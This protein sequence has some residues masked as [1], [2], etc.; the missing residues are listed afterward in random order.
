MKKTL[1]VFL[2]LLMLLSV[3]GLPAWAENAVPEV[4]SYAE[5]VAYV[6]SQLTARNGSFT[7][8]YTGGDWTEPTLDDLC[9]Y[10]GDAAAGDYLRLSFRALPQYADNGDGTHTVSAAFY[11]DEE[12]EAAVDAYVSDV[13]LGCT[14][15][16]DYDKA[17][18]IYGYLCDN[19]QFDLENLY[20]EED[21]LKYT[22]YGAAVNGRAVCQG[23]AT[24]FYRLALAAG[25]DCRIVTGTRSDVKHAWNIVKWNGK[26]YHVDAACGAQLLDPSGY[27]M[28]ASLDKYTI[29]Y[30]NETAQEIKNYPFAAV[31]EEEIVIG[32]LG[33]L[34]SYTL[35]NTTGALTVSGTGDVPDGNYSPLLHSVTSAVFEEGITGI[36]GA[37]F[38]DCLFLKEVS[39]PAS[40][41]G[42]ERS[43]FYYAPSIETITVDGQNPVF[44]AAGNCLIKT[45][46]KE[47]YVGCKTSEIPSDGSVTGIGEYAFYCKKIQTVTIPDTVTEIGA[48]A[49]FGAGLTEITIP[50]SVTSIGEAAFSSNPLTSVTVG[51][52][53]RAEIP[54]N[55]FFNC[56]YIGEYCVEG[57]NG[58]Y[59]AEN[60][61]L[62]N[63]DGTVLIRY[64]AAASAESFEIP[65]S[66]TTVSE[67]AFYGSKNLKSVTVPV[68][69]VSLMPSVFS[70][71]EALESVSFA[72]DL[73]QIPDAAFNGCVSL[74]QVNI[75]T[76]VTGIGHDAFASCKALTQIIL[77][78]SVT[79]IDENAFYECTSL[80]EI[81]IPSGVTVIGIR[82]F[83]GCRSLSQIVL[84]AGLTELG[85]EAFDY[86]ISLQ[87]DIRVPGSVKTVGMNTFLNCK[88]LTSVTLGSGV[89]QIGYQA[90]CGCSS[91]NAVVVPD[92]VTS[93]AERAFA[94]SGATLYGVADSY[95]QT[96]AEQQNIP[97]KLI[98]PISG[99]LHRAVAE[100]ATEATCTESA[101][102][103]G[104][105]CADCGAWLTEPEPIG[106]P[107]GHSPAEPVQENR[108]EPTCTQEGA[109]DN[110]VRCSRC[111]EILSSVHEK[112]AMIP[113]ADGDHNGYC[114][115]C[116]ANICEHP[117]TVLLNERESTCTENGYSGD[118]VCAV[119]GVT[120]TYGTTVFAPGHSPVLAAEAAAATCVDKGHTAQYV[121]SA[122]GVVTTESEET[123][124]V[125]HSDADGGGLCDVC[126]SP[127]GCEIFG[128]CGA[129]LFWFAAD[130]VL[131]ISGSGN[132]D[133]F[134]GGAPWEPYE[135]QI[136]TVYIREGV[137]RVYAAGLRS[138]PALKT[139]LKSA[140]ARV[141]GVGVPV[142]SYAFSDGDALL[143]GAAEYT[144]YDL[145]DTAYLLTFDHAVTSLHFETLTLNAA[146]G[147][148]YTEYDILKNGKIIDENHFRIPDGAAL[149]DVRVA[150][151]G[152]RSFNAVL[153][154]IGRNPDKNLILNITCTDLL[155]QEL[156]ADADLYTEQIA[157]R[158]IDEEPSGDDGNGSFLDWIAEQYQATL[159]ALLGL[160]KKVVKFFKSI[161][162]K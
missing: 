23:F 114:D 149:T 27:F 116:G 53:L 135:D 8:R 155:P 126:L 106:D 59:S 70:G 97:F 99:G 69:V 81:N 162:S 144:L 21:L 75:P 145:L 9:A 1:S 142:V 79:E 58:C 24:L 22:A 82:A 44:H 108:T 84:P 110:V 103:A 46:E 159:A 147:A 66:V 36:P 31:S 96:W 73:T 120:L 119:C 123:P 11:T 13:I 136:E 38:E 139:V 146:D 100:D 115:D 137:G 131:V 152:Y 45:A 92:S 74:A 26:W 156:K 141:S 161:F 28:R 19:V 86:C 87:G 91:L 62:Y 102:S 20:N 150:P 52:G 101:Y 154:A 64:P 89:L 55:A 88:A 48:S 77:P 41:T 17:A 30:G 40:M 32:A 104:E 112:L 65:D 42:I 57:N 72:G 18:Y 118:T 5:T 124:T 93:I 128:R 138:C 67:Q 109:Y 129:H 153:D 122:C 117:E 85:D 51:A 143:S 113:H 68:S 71:C 94:E 47:L 130:D 83:R 3:S 105:K 12:Q 14:A 29:V 148:E 37:F 133:S 111:G 90:F 151:L 16:T 4:A 7:F 76:G 157:I 35:N 49:F 158:F 80:D 15:E 54:E 121:C 132:S 50:G 33:Y 60:G 6:R 63:G 140:S 107:L 61:V 160:F 56:P 2:S 127:V 34:I 43:A 39:F 10:G 98:C 95:A 78:D 125:G 134:S 25:I